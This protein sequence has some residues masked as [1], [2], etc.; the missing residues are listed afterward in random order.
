MMPYREIV[1]IIQE[2]A[3]Y[4][5]QHVVIRKLETILSEN[6]LKKKPVKVITGI[7]R[8][9]KSFILKRL[10]EKISAEIPKQNI[11]FINFENDRLSGYLTLE[12]LRNI[13]DTFKLN[14]DPGYPLYLFFDEIQN[15][16]AWEKFI[17]TVYD[18]GND[19]IYITGSNSQLLSSEFSTVIGGR[20]L[21]YKL[22]TFTFREFLDFHGYSKLDQFSINEKKIE[23]S[24][25]FDTYLEYGGFYETFLLTEDQK[26]IY[27]QSLL[28][29]IVLKDIINRYRINKP[30]IIQNLFLYVAKNPGTIVSAAKLSNAMG[31]NDK[32]VSLFLS[33][34][35][36][37]FLL[38]RIDKYQWKTKKIFQ[39]QKKY[40][41]S[42][43]LF[44]H[45]CLESR[46]LENF[47]YN[48]LVE[49]YSGSEVLFLRD[50][51]GHEVDFAVTAGGHYHCY[52]VCTDLND[53]NKN[54][55][56]RSLLNL[57]K[58]RTAEELK[59]DRYYLLYQTDSRSVKDSPVG[60]E[61][62]Q[63]L[64][65]VLTG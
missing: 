35:S 28:E 33:Y 48:H 61:V 11:L 59:D 29:K 12:S 41:L 56:F 60:I 22:Q 23:L 54:R 17:R 24:Q 45:L 14:S 2:S 5:T 39:T 25:L 13:Y 15:I 19:D 51:K 16:P 26:A 6:L 34:L 53:E 44:T 63:V 57:R 10:Y 65:F 1:T 47:V 46:R 38:G 31:I 40:Y 4:Q 50:E 52:Q 62:R 9:G 64:D 43:N 42:D 20:V 27:R 21:E 7:R 30:D 37:V 8:S 18:S 55:E 32:T 3:A 58:Y 49:K 36:N